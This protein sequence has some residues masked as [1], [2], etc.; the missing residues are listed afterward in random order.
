MGPLTPPSSSGPI[1][2]FGRA[3]RHAHF[4]FSPGY[5]PLNHGSYGTHPVSVRGTHAALL[6]EVEAAPDR[7]IVLEWT[8]RLREARAAAAGV[9]GCATDDL[10]FV[11]NATTGVDTVLKNLGWA[12]GDVVLVYDVVYDSVRAGLAWLEET[13]GV[14]VEVVPLRLPLPDDEIVAA[15]VGA[16]RRVNEGGGGE[17]VRLA[18]VDTI[19]SMP[20]IRIP[21]EA[22]VPALQAEDVLVLVDGAHGIGHVDIDLAA[23]QPDFFVTNLHKWLFVPRAV[24]ALYVPRQHQ[25]LIRT[26]L[27]TSYRYRKRGQEGGNEAF[28]DLFDFVATLDTTHYLTVKD[29]LE[30]RTKVCGGERAIQTYCRAVA[31]E[32]AEVAA[33]LLGTE[34]MDSAGSR[35]RECNFANVRLPLEVSCEGGEGEAADGKVDPKNAGRLGMWLKERGVVESGCYFQTC[36]YRGA[37]WWRLSGM[38][39]VDVEDFRKGAEALQGLC[40]RARAGEYLGTR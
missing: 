31:R 27:P 18:I 37:L 15:V 14:R 26:S 20:G 8:A 11:P 6:S 29:A 12:R 7:F 34:V 30:F 23:L 36:L 16:A 17:R 35:M 10:V 24:A 33:G 1:V 40:E 13:F 38:I 19:V 4:A 22:L 25:G 21:F 28:L 32:G 5:T 3:M 39:Y 9:L 2:P